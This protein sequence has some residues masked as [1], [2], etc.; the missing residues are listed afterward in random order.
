MDEDENVEEV[1]GSEKPAAG[2][3]K[4]MMILIVAL[5]LILIGVIVAVAIVI[6][7]ALN[8]ENEPVIMD[9]APPLVTTV[10]DITF[11]PLGAPIATNLLTGPDGRETMVI[12]NFSVGVNHTAEG[13]DEMV[14]LVEGAEPLI[15]N[16]ALNVLRDMTNAEISARGGQQIATAEIL[17]RI[18]EEFR[19]NLITDIF[20]ID[21]ATQ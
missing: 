17:R 1:A 21:V 5:L 6:L 19:T 18:Q 11:V 13:G 9:V 12:F 3:N 4:K 10:E 7:G 15:R 20:V 8:S 2:G 16:I 14:E